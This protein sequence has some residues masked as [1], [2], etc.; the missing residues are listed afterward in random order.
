MV[1]VLLWKT[2]FEGGSGLKPSM[3]CQVVNTEW[4]ATLYFIVTCFSIKI[5]LLVA[6]PVA[7]LKSVASFT[8]CKSG[9]R[10]PHPFDISSLSYFPQAQRPHRQ[11]AH[12]HSMSSLA[13]LQ[14]PLIIRSKR[15][16]SRLSSPIPHAC[17]RN[18]SQSP[19]LTPPTSIEQTL[20]L[21][22]ISLDRALSSGIKRA[23][24]TALIPGLN[25]LIEETVPYSDSLLNTF[26]YSLT[27]HSDTLSSC[28]SVALLFKSAGTA[29]AARFQY[30][31]N[32]DACVRFE[33]YFRRDARTDAPAS[34][35]ANVIV[36]PTSARGDNIMDDL[37]TVVERAPDALW[38]VLN[39]DMGVDRAA[40][41]MRESARRDRFLNSFV[42]V[43][44]IRN[45]VSFKKLVL[46]LAVAALYPVQMRKVYIFS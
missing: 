18:V 14:L 17:S 19:P 37:E 8:Y 39:A 22:A 26:S 43:F 35:H 38:V 5:L 44:Y 32:D 24:I 28:S 2:L 23:K 30:P 10:R 34:P 13:F 33:S 16:P 6:D 3:L 45:L 46:F 12:H 42:D 11:F 31:D 29:A 20:S 25:P 36:N 4:S 15:R 9:P 27:R 7:E 41:G 1:A 21:A 40:V